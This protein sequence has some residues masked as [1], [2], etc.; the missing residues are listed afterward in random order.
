M[1]KKIFIDVGHGGSDPGAQA[2]GII[3]KNINLIVALKLKEL[4]LNRGFQVKLSREIDGYLA[5]TERCNM[6][7]SWGAD[8]FISIHHNAGGGDGWEIIH[9]IHTEKSEGDELAKYVGEEFNKT[10]Q[11]MR[12]IFSK[13]STNYPGTDY[14][15]VIA[16]AKMPAIITEYAFLDS[17]DYKAVDSVDKLHREAQAIADGLCNYLGINQVEKGASNY[18]SDWNEKNKEFIKSVQRAIGVEADGLAGVKTISAFESFVKSK[19]NAN[20]IKQAWNKLKEL[21]Q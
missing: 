15:T 12:R 8:Y 13:E 7:N 21:L 18:M 1:T 2:N 6:A 11:N 14:F 19:G 16:K 3:E 4:L 20:E 17:A 10:G 9:S 5:L